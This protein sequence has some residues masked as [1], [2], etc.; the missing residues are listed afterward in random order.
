M[1]TRLRLDT[2]WQH[3]SHILEQQ[4]EFLRHTL[5]STAFRAVVDEVLRNPH[6]RLEAEREE[7]DISRRFKPGRGFAWQIAVA[8]QRV[9]VPA[10]HPLQ[11]IISSLPARVSVQSRFDFLDT[12][13][14]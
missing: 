14:N 5:G 7:R 3:D 4:F 12:A 6:R 9:V 1:P 2:L 8:S 11:P 10:A 13:E